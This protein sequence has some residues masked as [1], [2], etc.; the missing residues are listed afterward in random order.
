LL[1]VTETVEE[2]SAATRAWARQPFEEGGRIGDDRGAAALL[3]ERMMLSAAALV[4]PSCRMITDEQKGD[5][6]GLIEC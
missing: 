3:T 5:L 1:W 2:G 6:V 4:M